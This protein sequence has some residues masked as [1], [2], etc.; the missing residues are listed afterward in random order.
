MESCKANWTFRLAVPDDAEAF[1]KWAAENPH[2]D[3]KDLLAGTK[4]QNP[5]VLFFVVEKDGVVQLFAP[6]YLQM[7]LAF[8]G[9]NPEVDGKDR[10]HAMTTLAD[11]VSALAVQFGVRELMVMS[12]PEYP[13]AQWAVKHDFDLEPRQAFKLDLNRVLDPVNPG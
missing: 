9:F 1:S 13:V 6:V 7:M 3:T 11:G 12:K 8:L 2:I 5:T 4:K 10:L